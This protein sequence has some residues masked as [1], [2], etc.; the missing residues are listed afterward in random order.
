M[1]TFVVLVLSVLAPLALAQDRASIDRFVAAYDKAAVSNDD[2][3]FLR[4]LDKK[5]K[6][7]FGGQTQT[8]AQVEKMSEARKG[9]PDPMPIVSSKTHVDKATIVGKQATVDYT[10]RQT[11]KN[12]GKIMTVKGHAVAIWKDGDWRMMRIESKMGQ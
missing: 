6:I 3:W 5:G 4:H 2:A 11:M 7:V 9:K 10:T 12:G 8:Y 1:K